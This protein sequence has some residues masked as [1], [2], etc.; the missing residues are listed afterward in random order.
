MELP[1]VVLYVGAGDGAA[2]VRRRLGDRSDLTVEVAAGQRDGL[3]AVESGTVDCVVTEQSLREGD[4]LSLLRAVRA[5]DPSLPVLLFA[6]ADDEAL[7]RDALA[8]DATGFVPRVGD[9]GYDLL[10]DRIEAVLD[11]R[12]TERQATRYEHIAAVSRKINRALLWARDRQTL[13]TR[14]CDI[15]TESEPY[16]FAWIGCHDPETDAIEPRAGGGD[17]QGYLDVVDVTA[18]AATDHGR[19]PA[20]RAIR[21]GEIQVCQDI[22]HAP[23][24]EPWREAAL[25]RGFRSVAAVPL[26]Y[27]GESYGALFVY[28]DRID[29]F[30]ASELELLSDIGRDIAYATN[31]LELRDEVEKMAE[32]FEHAPV[33]VFVTEPV[34]GG[35][36]LE[37]NPALARLFGTESAE[38]LVGTEVVDV[39]ANPEERETVLEAIREHGKVSRELEL[40][41]VG[42][43]TIWG[44]L[45]LILSERR[46]G[47]PVIVG[48]VKDITGK[49]HIQERLG[50]Q[51]AF[52]ES[53]LESSP[54]AI[55]VFDRD[56]TVLR[57][58]GYAKEVLGLETVE[59]LG[60][61]ADGAEWQVFDDRTELLDVD[62]LPF[63]RVVATGEPVYGHEH[64]IE[65]SDGETVWLSTNMVPMTNG[66]GEVVRAV[67]AIADVTELR[68]KEAELQTRQ[69]QIAFFNN[70]LRHE[71]LNGMT[72]VLGATERL[73]D[74][75]DEDDERRALVEQIDGRG[76]EIVDTVQRVRRVLRQIADES[77]EVEP[78]DLA[79]VVGDCVARLE[80]DYPAA[81]VTLDAPATAP[82]LADELLEE[83]VYNVLVNAVEHNDAG[84]PSAWVSVAVEGETTVV[85]IEDDGPGI[86]PAI[87]DRVFGRDGW[88]TAP[89]SAS[90]F[91]L[92][93]VET[94]VAQYG[95][96]VRVEDREPRGTRIVLELPT[97]DGD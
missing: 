64:V 50:E 89:V 76:V 35:V 82:V 79:A 12:S 67:A 15:L 31:T 72:V 70:L 59:I 62:D 48:M 2:A 55:A 40:E 39:Y 81:A 17:E 51:L 22:E 47:Q 24:F 65:Q 57:A 77:P 14:V 10:V 21:T 7:V 95:G 42:G 3:A 33:G 61:S 46:D 43:Q 23:S 69:S 13:E 74:A 6:P 58:N 4:G 90:G 78:H 68:R 1:A 29:A 32:F 27:G 88:Q 53:V 96:S 9:A 63:G 16:R 54:V 56:G 36:V 97:A 52:I 86:D 71:V 84:D 41:T 38:D 87:R 94:M 91:G 60:R 18:A 85:R 92:H 34:E 37:A 45:T 8:D 26:T 30:D 49:K 44:L 75:L 83:V 5:A 25:E 73:L 11:H 66:D 19:G 20:G 80:L 93:F 28:A